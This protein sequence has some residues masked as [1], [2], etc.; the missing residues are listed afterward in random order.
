MK[1]ELN[2]SG[3]PFPRYRT[4]NIV[5]SLI[6]VLT[7]AFCVWQLAS[8][9]G[10]AER[11]RNLRA[12]EQDLRTEWQALGSQLDGINERLRRPEALDE[13]EEIRFLNTLIERQLFSWSVF[14]V[15]IERLIPRDVY[16][17][18]LQPE[19]SETGDVL[20]RMDAR[21]RTISALSQFIRDLE[22]ADTFRN[23]TVLNEAHGDVDSL[24]EEVLLTMT[25][26][27]M[28]PTGSLE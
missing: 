5:F 8:F 23:V 20:V 16:L 14:L 3:Y 24:S 15:E 28:P 27:Y 25:A 6:F 1:Y 11:V 10:Y 19:I 13:M 18:A 9:F 17:A 7:L 2:L 4:T 26:E 21:G 12:V 22:D